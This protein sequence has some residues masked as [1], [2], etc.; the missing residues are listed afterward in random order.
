MEQVPLWEG[1]LTEEGSPLWDSR[2]N[3]SVDLIIPEFQNTTGFSRGSDVGKSSLRQWSASWDC[4]RSNT[5]LD[6]HQRND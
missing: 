5:I 1:L 2:Y 4:S 6:L 3:K